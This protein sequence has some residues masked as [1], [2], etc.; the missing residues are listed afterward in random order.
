MRRIFIGLI[1]LAIGAMMMAKALGYDFFDSILDADW[2]K[3][4][5]PGIVLLIGLRLVFGSSSSHGH[6]TSMKLCEVPEVEE[7]EPMNISVTFAGNA[8][9]F[10]DENFYGAKIDAVFGGVCMDLRGANIKDGSVLDIHTLFGGVELKIPQNI[11]L[12]V[13]SSC[14]LGGVDNKIPR[15][16]DK[17]AKKLSPYGHYR[18]YF[19]CA[20]LPLAPSR[21]KGWG[22]G[23]LFCFFRRQKQIMNC[24]V[25][26]EL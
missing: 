10:R 18:D 21:G 17:D 13:D 4:I 7:G 15:C 1:I 20:S 12:Q 5:I 16:P 25:A 14:I 8:Y 19:F 11:S 22:K 24:F 9:N 3:F 26:N 23:S 2:K 6:S